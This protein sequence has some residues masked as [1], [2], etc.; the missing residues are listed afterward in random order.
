[1]A[2]TEERQLFRAKLNTCIFLSILRSTSYLSFG[3][4]RKVRKP[5]PVT[6]VKP[7]SSGS[8][9][10]AAAAAEGADI[11][12]DTE[13]QRKSRPRLPVDDDEES[14]GAQADEEPLAG[15]RVRTSMANVDTPRRRAVVVSTT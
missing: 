1:M 4:Y 12:M 5:D 14:A 13:R 3:L 6:Q 7:S 8:F 9:L 2:Y 11:P 15:T 10:H